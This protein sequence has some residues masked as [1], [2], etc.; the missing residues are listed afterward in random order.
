MST[1]L[2]LLGAQMVALCMVLLLLIDAEVSELV[3][4]I[5]GTGKV[6]TVVPVW[7]TDLSHIAR[8]DYC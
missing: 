1:Q 5:C 2:C 7:S 6:V 3:V 8:C 4:Y